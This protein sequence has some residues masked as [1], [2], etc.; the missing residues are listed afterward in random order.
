MNDRVTGIVIRETEVKESDAIITVYTA[1]H[2]QLSL[3]ARGLRKVTSRNAYAC[4]LFDCSEFLLDYNPGKDVQL[5]K[6]A[7]LKREYMGIRADYDRLAL[8]SVVIEIISQLQDDSLYEL[9]ETTLEKLDQDEEAFTAFS[10]FV[11]QILNILG[12]SPVVDECVLCGNTKGI[13][14]ISI[15]DGGFICH[16]C[17]KSV[18]L[19]PLDV[20]FLRKFRII[21]KA[22]FE[23]YDRLAS[24]GLNDY[25]LSALLVEFLCT[26][27]GMRLRSWRAVEGAVK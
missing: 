3:Y 15:A 20:D 22:S 6:S 10:V 14:T 12:I 26:H 24:S 13:E 2:G 18:H 5:L 8:A 4:Q 16:E 11:V 17:N 25:Q 27:S 19:R 9:L 1:D 7:V 21:N 23:V